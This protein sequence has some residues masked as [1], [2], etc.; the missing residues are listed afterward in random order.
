MTTIVATRD[1]MVSDS[2]ATISSADLVYPATKIFRAKGMVVGA[3]GDNGDCTRFIE[4]A[5][6]GFKG[7]PEFTFK[8]DDEEDSIIGLVLKEDGIYIFCPS[9]PAP[10][11]VNAEFFAIGSGGSAALVAMHLGKT[12]EEAVELACKVD[13]LNSGLPLQVLKLEGK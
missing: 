12:P 2:K 1:R 6:G 8:K 4:W 11:K 7:K 9:Y 3:C 10:E 13:E 5:Q